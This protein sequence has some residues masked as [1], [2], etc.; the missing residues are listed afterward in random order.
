MLDQVLK[1]MIE[2]IQDS[3]FYLWNDPNRS[4]HKVHNFPSLL[5]H[6][7]T[8]AYSTIWCIYK[9]PVNTLQLQHV[10]SILEVEV[11]VAQN[12]QNLKVVLE[13]CA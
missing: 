5:L 11:E 6:F 13:Y 3:A 12:S 4:V 2:Y 7:V 8:M 9:N 1:L 10:Y